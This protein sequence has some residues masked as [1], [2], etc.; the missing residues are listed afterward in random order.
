MSGSSHADFFALAIEKTKHLVVPSISLLEVFNRV[1]QQVGEKKALQEVTLMME[2]TVV[3]LY[4]DLAVKAAVLGY[5]TKL[6]LA[7]RVI[8]AIA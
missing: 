7:D 6:P 1:L 8:L 3:D 5:K 4:A 2:G